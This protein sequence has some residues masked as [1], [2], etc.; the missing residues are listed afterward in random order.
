MRYILIII[1]LIS[2]LTLQYSTSIGIIGSIHKS[3]PCT[4]NN[5]DAHTRTITRKTIRPDPKSH[6]HSR[7][8]SLEETAENLT[9]H[10]WVAKYASLYPAFKNISFIDVERS[11]A[12]KNILYATIASS[13]KF[14]N[15]SGDY[16][17][18]TFRVLRIN[19]SDI[20]I[21]GRY[22]NLSSVSIVAVHNMTVNQSRSPVL[23]HMDTVVL[24]NNSLILAYSIKVSLWGLRTSLIYIY[25]YSNLTLANQTFDRILYIDNHKWERIIL[26]YMGLAKE[27]NDFAFAYSFGYGDPLNYMTNLSYWPSGSAKPKIVETPGFVY[28]ATGMS[29]VIL[30]NKTIYVVV[31]N[32]FSPSA[33]D[34]LS[35]IIWDTTQPN[36][37]WVDVYS[38]SF[39]YD[40][41]GD[42][43]HIQYSSITMYNKSSVL[44]L[45]EAHTES[46]QFLFY[47]I[48]PDTIWSYVLLYESN[49]A[50][51]FIALDN[52]YSDAN[53]AFL[54]IEYDSQ[55]GYYW[56]LH[57]LCAYNNTTHVLDWFG[58]FV[59]DIGNVSVEKISVMLNISGDIMG[60]VTSRSNTNIDLS[61]LVIF[62]DYDQD[63][64]GNYEEKILNTYPD[65]PDSDGEGIVDGSEIYLYQT[66]P[67]SNDS[68]TDGLDDKFELEVRP[69]VI[70]P[71]YGNIRNLYKTDPNDV[72]TDDDNLSDYDE[73]TGEYMVGGRKGYRTNPLSNDTDSD[74]LTDY[75]EIC[76]GVPYWINS[77]SNIYISYPNA[78]LEDSDG[79]GLTDYEESEA[80]LNPTSNDTDGDNLIDMHEIYKFDTDPH[81]KDC[82]GDGLPDDEILNYRTDPNN[83]DTDEDMLNDYDEIMVYESDPRNPDTDGDR[84]LDGE[85]ILYGS[86]LKDNDT[87]DDG[88]DD[89]EEA[90]IYQTSPVLD[91][92]DGDGL[93]DYEEVRIYGTNPLNPDTDED[94]LD[95]YN[96]TKIY[97]TNPLDPDTDGDRLN[98][99][100]ELE[101]GTDP[102]LID[103]DIDGLNDWDEIIV[104]N[105]NPL[106]NDTDNDGL[107][108][109]EE[110]SGVN[111]PDI[112]V[113]KTNPKVNDSD[114]D[115]LTDGAEVN[116]HTDPTKMDTD[117]D[118]LS[119]YEEIKTYH[120][121]ATNTDSDGDGLSDYEEVRVFYTDP[122]DE[123]SD[124]DNIS[125]YNETRI[126]GT[127]PND[128][129]SDNDGL[130]DYDEI[131]GI[132]I[133]GIGT[134]V[135]DPLSNDTDRDG[136]SDSYEVENKLNPT[137]RDT[138]GDGLGDYEEIM[139]YGTDPKSM[140]T[141]GD[142]LLD[143]EEVR[144]GT[145]PASRDTDHDF[146][147]DNIDNL[148]PTFPDYFIL[149]VAV[150]A[151]GLYRTY[152]YGIFRNWKKDL[153]SI[154]LADIGGVPMFIVPEDFETRYDLSL[155]SSGLLGI[156][157]MTGEITGKEIETLVLSGELPI[158]ISRGESSILFAFMRKEYPRL[159]KQLQ[160]LHQDTEQKY[161][162]IL[163]S[164]AGMTEEVYEIKY[165]IQTKIG[166]H[167]TKEEIPEEEL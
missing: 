119:D 73:V 96:E 84:L 155:I 134:L 1:L 19:Y 55:S 65:N 38:A 27:N 78:T 145:N 35:I 68:D 157:T 90:K 92:T 31:P 51:S 54:F 41:F 4:S 14:S 154:G 122:L 105:T 89:Y 16:V 143:G 98:D 93:D 153:L 152:S 116:M 163:T 50:F 121:D 87:D 34:Y 29:N 129:D 25:R 103:T 118:G 82:D 49:Y 106:V 126:Y 85:E 15:S 147:P 9:T 86:D 101:L 164:W 91:D 99:S 7:Q 136:L 132:E 130:T 48:Y 2:T 52:N 66:D 44:I 43:P 75:K 5:Y 62:R 33:E 46:R 142:T 40:L 74:G 135:L 128:V 8:V 114:E 131:H 112:G 139:I 42:I 24:D 56:P 12:E 11:E 95:D 39:L 60:L 125:D 137:K 13:Y 144:R 23:T 26:S 45:W 22:A 165:W 115:G 166:I 3:S 161:T 117:S 83:P 167:E 148:L 59:F 61:S 133:E 138:D 127:D 88:L 77:S 102:K 36:S 109:Y 67:K 10:G 70:Y 18:F 20:S 151:I 76:L 47:S 32:Y 94:N 69:S 110:I 28:E 104:Y 6:L 159:I 146:I 79:D 113:R 64:L 72:D 120:T 108:D 37:T 21:Y 100:E 162:D 30:A 97:G 17:N 156:Y 57:F 71:K 81:I 150:I 58:P 53:S 124:G 140:D 111:I 141:D 107:T 63:F 158:F 80:K 149:L 160:K 123:D